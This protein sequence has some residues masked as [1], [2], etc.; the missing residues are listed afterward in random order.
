M[1]KVFIPVAITFYLLLLQ[2]GYAQNYEHTIPYQISVYSV[3]SRFVGNNY[4]ILPIETRSYPPKIY[5]TEDGWTYEVSLI[6]KLTGENLVWK[7]PIGITLIFPDGSLQNVTINNEATPLYS[8][9]H[10]EYRFTVVSRSI[11]WAMIQMYPLE[12]WDE[13][14]VRSVDF[15]TSEVCLE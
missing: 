8:N 1:R 11:G 15:R 7:T 5:K 6:I 12:K 14:N 13:L 2:A 4:R 9:N 3:T 10:Y